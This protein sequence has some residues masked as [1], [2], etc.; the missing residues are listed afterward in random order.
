MD[1]AEDVVVKNVVDISDVSDEVTDEPR[2][3]SEVLLL[4]VER[5]V[6]AEGS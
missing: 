4:S 3:S 6:E 1:E 5:L 2:L